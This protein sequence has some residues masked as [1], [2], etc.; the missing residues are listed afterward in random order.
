MY[1]NCHSWFSLRY[2]TLAPKELVRIAAAKGIQTLALTDINNTSCAYQFIQA[3][4]RHNIS[5]IL[6]IEYRLNNEF[7]Y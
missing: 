2:G 3:C 6:G 4:K 5:P 1:L 7:L